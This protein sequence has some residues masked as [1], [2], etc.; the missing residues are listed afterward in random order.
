MIDKESSVRIV[1]DKPL[2]PEISEDS[3]FVQISPQSISLRLRPDQPVS[4]QF[5]VAHAKDFPI[6]LYFLM[7]LSWSMKDSRENL[8]NLGGEII[9]T[10]KEKTQNLATGFGSF[11][12]KNVQPFSSAISSYNCGNQGD[13]CPPPYSF[14]HKSS[15]RNISSAEFSQSVLDSPMGGNIDDPEASLEA[16]M[17]VMI[18]DI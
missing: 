13:A 11:I 10:I 7:D 3:Q 14:Y 1:E 4:F 9:S 16:L 12:E 5:Q 8:A 17:Q 6:D 15:L 18:Y 2:S